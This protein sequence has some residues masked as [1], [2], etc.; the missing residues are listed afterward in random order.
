ME[1]TQSRILLT[2]PQIVLLSESVQFQNVTDPSSQHLEKSQIESDL[3]HQVVFIAFLKL[4]YI[5]IFPPPA[6]PASVFVNG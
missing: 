4:C 3:R 5:F 1:T 2:I 6:P